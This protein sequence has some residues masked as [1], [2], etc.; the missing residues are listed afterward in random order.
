MATIDFSVCPAQTRAF[1]AFKPGNT[2]ALAWGRG[3]GKSWFIRHLAYLLVAEHDATRGVRIVFLTPTLKQ[4]K[5][6]HGNLLLNELDEHGA[7]GHLRGVVNRT[8][9]TTRFPG[10][11]TIT[12]VSAQNS[13]DNRGLRC[14]A[15]FIDEADSIDESIYD[16]VVAPWLSEPR[17][18]RQVVIGGTPLRGRYGLLWKAFSVWPKGDGEHDPQPN[19]YGFHATGYDTTT[20]SHAYMDA[21]RRK[22]RPERFAR[23]WLCSFDAGEG[24]VYPM[25]DPE[26]HVRHVPPRDAISEYIVGIDYGFNDPTAIV[27]VAVVG[28]GRDAVCHVADERFLVGATASEIA[29]VAANLESAYPGARWYA[30]HSPM[31]TKTLR[32][33]AG[34]RIQ[35]A[36]K[37]KDSIEQGVQFVSDALWVRELEDGDRFCQLYVSPTCKRT[38]DEFGLYRRRRDPRNQ[39]RV[40]DDIDRNGGNDHFMDALRYALM[41]HFGVRNN[42]LTK[43]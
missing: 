17:S 14:D 9:W 34:I 5:R 10:G 35:P 22:T 16:F 13:E 7:W 25:F 24:L 39:D 21:V 12:V 32:Q 19:H 26:F 38:I 40:L 2:I 11:S 37:G 28:S 18:L 33:E 4:F 20:V 3:V 30:D 15:V 6:N 8:D 1:L 42:A 41:S 31:I 43:G 27:V 23:E 36:E 29:A